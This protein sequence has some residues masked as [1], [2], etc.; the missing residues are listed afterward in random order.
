MGNPVEALDHAA[1]ILTH[2]ERAGL[3]PPWVTFRHE[4]NEV[5]QENIAG[6]RIWAFQQKRRVL[7]DEAFLRDLHKRMLG[8]VW[9]WA[10]KYRTTERNIGVPAWSIATDLRILLDDARAWIEFKTY[11]PDELAVRLHHRLVSIHPFP[12]GNGRHSRLMADLVLR[13]L[14]GKPFT[15]GSATLSAAGE[16]RARYI[17]ALQQADRHSVA[18]LLEFAKS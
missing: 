14:G 13:Q 9:R 17:A 3:I 12:N 2:E 1:T 8:K 5:E 15:W 18:A 10:G 4:L 16:M 7:L 11:A 6:G